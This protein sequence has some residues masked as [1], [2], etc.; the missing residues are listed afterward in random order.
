MSIATASTALKDVLVVGFGAVG[1]I[2]AFLCFVFSVWW[3]EML[4]LFYSFLSTFTCTTAGLD[5]HL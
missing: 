1:A 4:I 3:K 5:A 2:C